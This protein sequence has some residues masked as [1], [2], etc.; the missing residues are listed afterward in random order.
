MNHVQPC[1][2]ASE[3]EVLPDDEIIRIG[4]IDKVLYIDFTELNVEGQLK[5]EIL[6]G[7][8]RRTVSLPP[9]EDYTFYNRY[10]IESVDQPSEA[11]LTF[12]KT[13]LHL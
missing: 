8:K 13:W 5:L 3:N 10:R 2:P 6:S 9:S 12:R 1:S 11:Q 7:G 4:E